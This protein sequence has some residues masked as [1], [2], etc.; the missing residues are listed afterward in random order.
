MMKKIAKKE[1]VQEFFMD[2]KLCSE[3]ESPMA[4]TSYS[5]FNAKDIKDCCNGVTESYG[6]RIW[7]WKYPELR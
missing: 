7:K 2:G 4:A 5:K 6:G 1:I 3:W